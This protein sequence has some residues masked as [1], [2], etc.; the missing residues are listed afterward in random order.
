MFGLV[1]ATRCIHSVISRFL[2]SYYLMVRIET[3]EYAILVKK[4]VVW[5]K[6]VEY[7]GHPTNELWKL[8]YRITHSGYEIMA[9]YCSL[10]YAVIIL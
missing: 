1:Y 10:E 5:M 9:L 3:V 8:Y 2:S 6:W 4:S 7:S